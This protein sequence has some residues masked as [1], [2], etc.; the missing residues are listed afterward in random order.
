MKKYFLFVV[1]LIFILVFASFTK[2]N[3]FTVGKETPVWQVLEYLGEAPPQH[4]FE[5]SS[6]DMIQRGKDLVI[7]GVTQSPSGKKTKLQSK[8]FKCIS[9]HN[10]VN[11]EGDLAT[12]DAQARLDFCNDNKLPFLQ[13]TT[14]YGIV[15]RT[16]F[17][18]GDYQKKYDGNPRII[19]SHKNLREAIQLCAVECAQGRPFKK[20]ELDAVLAYYWSI[21]MKMGDLN[22]S[23]EEFTKIRKAEDSNHKE[24][25]DLIHSK[26]LSAA[27][28]T[29]GITPKDA[30]A[31]F[32]NITG[33]P[34]NG[35]LIYD[36]SCLYCHED[37]KYS[38]YELDDNKMTFE[39]LKRH[40]P[41][42]DR[43]SIYQ[44]SR[45]GAPS[46][47]GKRAYMPQYSLE[48]MTDQQLE[49]LRAY[50][51]SRASKK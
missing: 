18:N 42:Y 26:Y 32:P 12:M 2:K 24:I 21:E 31:G 19:K 51:D 44:V 45:Y 14:F 10:I 49:D 38:M 48:K 39:H 17:Y 50:V 27:P 13:G 35:K 25:R 46:F 11:D 23:E 1:I 41:R 34:E 5:G 36:L 43:Y 6:K 16:S 8:H 20:W 3:N 15:N 7:K 47:P 4:S 22:F 40:I 37:K 33:H 29:F 30:K 28:A 9:C